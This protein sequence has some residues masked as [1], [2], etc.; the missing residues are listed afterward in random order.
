[1][2]GVQQNPTHPMII[3]VIEKRAETQSHIISEKIAK[4]LEITIIL[5]T[6]L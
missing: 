2:I 1:M 3:I 5:R 6:L 4:K